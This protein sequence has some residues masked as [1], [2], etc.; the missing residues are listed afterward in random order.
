MN[1]IQDIT[2]SDFYRYPPVGEDDWRYMYEAAKVRALEGT[3]LSRALL[4][5]MA[6]APDF[7]AAAELLSST[8][9]V[10]ASN[11]TDAQI[12]QMLLERRTATRTLFTELM[13]DEEMLQMMRARED[14]ANMRLAIRRLVTEK[15]LGLDYSNEGSVPAVEFEDILQQENYERLPDYLQDAVESAVLGYYENKNIRRID[16]GIDKVQYAWR[17]SRAQELG[18]VFCVSRSRIRVDLYNICTMLRLKMAERDEREFFFDGGFVDTDKFVQGLAAPYES[19]SGLFF[20]TPY[21]EIIEEGIR[22]LRSEQSFL[23]LEQQCEDYMMNFLKST[24]E[25]AAGPQPVIAYFLM[26][27][28][29]I[30]AVRMVLT[31]KKNGLTSKLILDRLG[32]WHS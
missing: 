16:Y 3:M 32:N 14:F 2:L 30:R 10:I 22:Y 12:E 23:K 18:S 26:K 8:E 13:I 28:A 1:L 5:D 20:A 25:I 6:N 4:A 31:G 24:K 9:Y 27:E 29:E 19:I 11:S 21:Y 7:A 15:P 17:I